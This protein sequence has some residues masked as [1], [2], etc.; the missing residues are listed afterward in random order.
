VPALVEG[1]TGTRAWMA[2][3]GGASKSEVAAA[4]AIG[5][6]GGRPKKIEA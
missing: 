3:R 6:R 5:K 4:R 2:A 1:V